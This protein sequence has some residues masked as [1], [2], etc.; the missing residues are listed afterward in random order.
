[1]TA[2]KLK[3]EI[4]KIWHVLIYDKISNKVIADIKLLLKL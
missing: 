4:K 1:M 3:R 2:V